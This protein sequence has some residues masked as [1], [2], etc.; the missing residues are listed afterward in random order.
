MALLRAPV[1]P[2]RVLHRGAHHCAAGSDVDD[3]PQHRAIV[4][5]AV[6]RH[7]RRRLAEAPQHHHRVLRGSPLDRGDQTPLVLRV[8]A[9]QNVRQRESREAAGSLAFEKGRRIGVDQSD[10]ARL[11]GRRLVGQLALQQCARVRV[12]PVRVPREAPFHAPAHDR[13]HARREKVEKRRRVDRA[14]R[15]E[16]KEPVHGHA[17]APG[18]EVPAPVRDLFVRI[19]ELEKCAQRRR[20]PAGRGRERPSERHDALGGA[21][22]ALLAREAPF[23]IGELGRVDVDGDDLVARR[24]LHRG[25]AGRRDA[26]DPAARPERVAF[27]RRVFVHATEQDLARAGARVEATALPGGPGCARRHHPSGNPAATHTRTRNAKF[28]TI[29]PAGS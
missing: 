23:G 1:S 28:F 9:V 4:G 27:D 24:E 29:I 22:H 3:A 12:R 13:A 11:R 16:R 20:V 2:P 18:V 7:F 14:Q 26:E 25:A 5:G 19:V 8:G 21:A 15:R 17:E 10:P 6:R